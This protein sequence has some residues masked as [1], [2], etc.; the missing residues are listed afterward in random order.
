MKLSALAPL[1]A[2]SVGCSRSPQVV[3]YSA[4][5]PGPL[6]LVSLSRSDGYLWAADYQQLY[7][8]RL[9]GPDL[10]DLRFSTIRPPVYDNGGLETWVPTGV[11]ALSDDEIVVA[12]YRAKNGLRLRVGDDGQAA[13]L[14]RYIGQLVGPENV[15]F[16]PSTDTLGFADYDGSALVVVSR[17]SAE[18]RWRRE[19]PQAHGVAFCG[20]AWYVTSLTN[21][22]I[23]RYDVDGTLLGESGTTGSGPGEYRWPVSMMCAGQEL[24]ILDAHLSRLCRLHLGNLSPTSCSTEDPR[25]GEQ[26]YLPYGLAPLALDLVALT[27]RGRTLLASAETRTWRVRQL[28]DVGGERPPSARPPVDFSDLST[29]CRNALDS[30]RH[31]IDPRLLYTPSCAGMVG[32]LVWVSEYGRLLVRERGK[33]MNWRL[34]SSESLWQ[35]TSYLYHTY[36]TS[37]DGEI[38]LTS[39]SESRVL[40]ISVRPSQ[41]SAMAERAAWR[42]HLFQI[43][44][45][46]KGV[47]VYDVEGR[48]TDVSR[49]LECAETL[50]A[51][52]LP[53]VPA[54]RHAFGLERRLEKSIA[55]PLWNALFLAIDGASV[56]AGAIS[57]TGACRAADIEGTEDRVRLF[58][59]DTL[60]V[61]YRELEEL[62]RLDLEQLSA[63][64]PAESFRFRSLI[65][66]LWRDTACVGAAGDPESALALSIAFGWVGGDSGA[67]LLCP[68]ERRP[69]SVPTPKVF[70]GRDRPAELERSSEIRPMST[71]P[72]TNAAKRSPTNRG[73]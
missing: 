21:R 26:V 17:E 53:T 42:G 15:A 20:D 68:P 10:E 12:N 23:L 4:L 44:A 49:E 55:F 73:Q 29:A 46:A 59:K 50:F 36:A 2:A 66:S 11:L 34:H 32:E 63:L 45:S 6:S 40:A 52:W 35:P 38:V 18:L 19:V 51:T 71:T 67:G 25:F 54:A 58:M 41:V 37:R 61:R 56:G 7:R 64:S 33:W 1:L 47:F 24:L 43:H 28:L 60:P 57:E 13:I 27:T 8:S 70:L 22:S 14:T 65:R 5:E 16:D 72:S 48:A 30:V 39:P 62:F 69:A 31:T 3:S 9:S